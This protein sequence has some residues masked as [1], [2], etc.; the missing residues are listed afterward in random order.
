M[1]LRKLRRIQ[2]FVRLPYS[3][4]RGAHR[5]DLNKKGIRFRTTMDHTHPTMKHAM[6][7]ADYEYRKQTL[8]TFK[9]MYMF[10]EH[11]DH[12]RPNTLKG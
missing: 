12:D 4:S 8:R 3:P 1:R 7:R 2:G 10:R 6:L 5:H 11:H 9:N